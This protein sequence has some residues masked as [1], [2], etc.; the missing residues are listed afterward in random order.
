MTTKEASVLI[1]QA[2]LQQGANTQPK[3]LAEQLT[4]PIIQIHNVMNSFNKDGLIEIGEDEQGKTYTVKNEEGLK[5]LLVDVTDEEP[6]KEDAPEPK[7]EK[8]V[9]KKKTTL[10]Q[11]QTGKY[12]FNKVVLSKSQCVLQIVTRYV[13]QQQPTL[14]QLKETFPDKIVSQFGVIKTLKEAQGLSQSRKRFHLKDHQ[15]LK[16]SDNHQVAV[17]NQW[18]QD[19]FRQLLEI[20]ETLGYKVKPE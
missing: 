12:V 18:T 9:E 4:I 1:A 15:I 5:A 14:A 13:E 3:A 17:T 8:K 7:T 6:K 11:K 16:T 19:R 20:A 10:K 2:L